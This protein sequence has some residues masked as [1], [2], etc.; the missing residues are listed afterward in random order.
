MRRWSCRRGGGESCQS[1]RRWVRGC[2]RGLCRG[3]FTIPSWVAVANVGRIVEFSDPETFASLLLVD[4]RWRSVCLTEEALV[5]QLTAL[6]IGVPP[7]CTLKDL[8][9][10]FQY[11][12]RTSLF[13]PSLR[14]SC[15]E[16]RLISSS[17]SSAGA[18]PGG[19]SF[20]FEF[21]PKGKLLVAYS[22]S[23]LVIFNLSEA[24][25]KMIRELKVT[26]RPTNVA[27]LDDSSRLAVLSSELIVSVYDLSTPTLK[28][29][30]SITLE[31]NPRTIALSPQAAV[32]AAAFNGGI[33]VYSLNEVASAMDQRSVSCD[34]MDNLK[35][36][37]DGTM[38]LGTTIHSKP[39][40]TVIISAPFF[41]VDMHPSEILAQMWTT[42]VLFP[43]SSRDSSHA[44]LLPENFG[45]EENGWAFSYDRVFEIFRAVRVDDL[46]N[47]QTYFP[48]PL[49]EGAVVAPGT[50]PAPSDKGNLVAVGYRGGDVYIYGIPEVLEA[51]P[52]DQN[53]PS[54]SASS[55]RNLNVVPSRHS[56][57]ASQRSTRDTNLNSKWKVLLENP[58]NV[59]VP[60]HKVTNS[61][62][63]TSLR[64][65]PS[66]RGVRLVGVSSG[67]LNIQGP[68]DEEDELMG[69][70]GGRIY[71]FEFSAT[72]SAGA[73]VVKRVEIGVA[74]GEDLPEEETSLES[75]VDLVRRR[76]VARNRRTGVPGVQVPPIPGLRRAS[77]TMSPTS[78]TPSFDEA[79]DE[80]YAPTL[81]RSRAV[82]A[83]AATVRQRPQHALPPRAPIPQYDD[84]DG[85]VAPPPA[86]SPNLP[87]DEQRL[88]A[89]PNLRVPLT[90]H[91]SQFPVSAPVSPAIF[92][93]PHASVFSS[94]PRRGSVPSPPHTA[95]L[96]APQRPDQ[97]LHQLEL[98]RQQTAQRQRQTQ[99]FHPPPLPRTSSLPIVPPIP[100]QHQN[101]PRPMP[102]PLAMAAIHQRAPPSPLPTP[103]PQFMQHHN[104]SNLSLAPPSAPYLQGRNISQLSITTPASQEVLSVIP[105]PAH[106]ISSHSLMSNG[107]QSQYA[108][109][110]SLPPPPHVAP[111]SGPQQHTPRQSIYSPQSLDQSY[112]V[113]PIPPIPQSHNQGRSPNRYYPVPRSGSRV[114]RR[115]EVGRGRVHGGGRRGS[116]DGRYSRGR[117]RRGRMGL[118]R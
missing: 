92:R 102:S 77:T 8:Y 83:R 46:R 43:R 88:D 13:G 33:E 87:S 109:S 12:V 29:L 69:Q 47:G 30:R 37:S 104:V 84:R 107:R 116:R 32:L 103:Q 6:D 85:W 38:L 57:N 58:R 49:H 97:N 106:N 34:A 73:R 1:R 27:I 50:L 105:N 71:I 108:P 52:A 24:E 113:P 39:P 66:E 44:T 117:G 78:P 23:R 41:S 18:F 25:P 90:L 93:S 11:E 21:S 111:H 98:A 76:T 86:Y 42:Q 79:F 16:I 45:D 2:P 68:E 118:A 28:L 63:I 15:T 9:D 54:S 65:S 80:P 36:S 51:S 35:F 110:V 3:L 20:R 26:R 74:D 53:R 10:R 59:F 62:N 19:D 94:P 5:H 56:S 70:D 67:G 96:S 72:P 55:S 101:I 22:S 60:G 31:N 14:P 75:R 82:V 40:S 91:P 99:S 61:P 7:E 4:K 115:V 112:V 89:A 81:P 17:P 64:F 114:R 48:G 100:S 95:P